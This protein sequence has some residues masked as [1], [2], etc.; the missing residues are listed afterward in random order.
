MKNRATDEIAKGMKKGEN[1]FIVHGNYIHDTFLCNFFSGACNLELVYK[2]F[3][4]N[5]NK[6][7][8][9]MYC[10]NEK[11]STYK[12]VNNEFS[13]CSESM[14]KG[15][16]GGALANMNV[17]NKNKQDTD[18][19]KNEANH[20]AENAGAGS[21]EDSFF[22]KSVEYAAKH[23]DEHIAFFFEDYEWTIGA[24]MSSN[25]DRLAYVEK[26]FDLARLKNVT[27]IV[28]ISQPKILEKYN[29]D[30]T[31]KNVIL[32]GSPSTEE[33]FRCYLR[34]YLVK[35]SEPSMNIST[36]N[37]LH[38]ISESMASGTKS[39]I[40]AIKVFEQVMGENHWS[41]I[42]RIDFADAVDKITDND[43]V[44]LDEVIIDEKIKHDICG[45]VDA[46]INGDP[47]AKGFV[48]TGPP[49]TGKTFLV[50]AIANEKNCFF[51]SPTLAELKG[52]YIGQSSA[53]VKRIF[54]TAR[55]NAPAILFID[56]ADTVFPRR[57]GLGESDSFTHD[58]V[59]QFLVEMDGLQTGKSE[60]FV[61][62]AT[63]MVEMLDRAILS[64]LAGNPIKIDLPRKEE[65][66]KLFSNLLAGVENGMSNFSSFEFTSDFLDKTERMSGRDI[67]TFVKTNLS[68]EAR[69]KGRTL[70]SYTDENETREL[71]YK[72]LSS[73]E[74]T[75]VRELSAELKADIISPE[76]SSLNYDNIIG[77]DYAKNTIDEQIRMF[78]LNEATRART[79]YRPSKGVLLYGPSG[80]GKTE[81]AA[82][83]A[84]QHKLYFIKITTETL[85]NG[86]PFQIL[87]KVFNG[88]VQLSKMSTESNGVVLFFD[89]FDEFM[90]FRGT[91]LTNL[92]D[93]SPMR[94]AGSKVIFI[95][96]TNFYSN[97]DRAVIRDG[98]IDEKIFVG[99]PTKEEGI[100]MVR[101]LIQLKKKNIE[102]CGD[103]IYESAYNICKEY[104]SR[105]NSSKTTEN[106]K[107]TPP[108]LPSAAA[109]KNFVE[110]L[111]RESYY[112][113]N[114][115]NCKIDKKTLTKL[116]NRLG[117]TNKT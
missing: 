56:E 39:L 7:K 1:L 69:S 9:F 73:F 103:N 46:F 25:D 74:K 82:A 43:K 49:G 32:I 42:D 117:V 26:L 16:T 24:Y 36:L 78:D 53:K 98:R 100:E 75:Y 70:A 68:E 107:N 22:K 108:P 104:N 99:N 3:F 63:N 19:A 48:L 30:I 6:F 97:L 76:D 87:G 51:L 40:N 57:D 27:V 77:L 62:A 89:E 10:K 55:A 47:G 45:R 34:S 60:V 105:S 14:F 41:K 71:F 90:P 114:G 11:F 79:V 91:L 109:I 72:A 111:A 65:R 29:I 52:E 12:M 2:N 21:K 17:G 106:D 93:S 96:A 38:Y 5:E 67:K 66:E 37:E 95:A 4:L 92:D 80:N 13:E 8:Y 20:Q 88:A 112:Q 44:T 33:I 115:E 59:N 23:P 81:L 102:V 86:N 84:G 85:S 94:A 58:M 116:C 110:W 15:K 54:D 101:S 61:I 28:S 35:T 18:E 50:K 64:R 31:G 83:A 113:Y